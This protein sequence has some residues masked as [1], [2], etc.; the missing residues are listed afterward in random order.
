M[1][2]IAL[3]L[4]SLSPFLCLFLGMPQSEITHPVIMNALGNE[5]E[6][7]SDNYRKQII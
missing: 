1:Q 6:L 2:P 7:K 3:C 5:H 4:E